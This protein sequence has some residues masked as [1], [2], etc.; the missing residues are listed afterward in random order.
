M[1]THKYQLYYRYDGPTYSQ[2]M[3]EELSAD[4]VR[5]RLHLFIEDIG[6]FFEDS[7]VQIEVADGDVVC[8][9]TELSQKDCDDQVK[10]CLNSLDL[11]ARKITG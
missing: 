6:A 11:Y 5:H 2:P 1:P 3:R 10:R 4:E 8:L 7:E 9:M